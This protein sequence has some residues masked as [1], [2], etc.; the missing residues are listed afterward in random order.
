MA[1]LVLLK[2]TEPNSRNVS[3]ESLGKVI[4][5]KSQSSLLLSVLDISKLNCILPTAFKK[6]RNVCLRWPEKSDVK[7]DN[8]KQERLNWQIICIENY[9]SYA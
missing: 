1:A 6:Q 3:W 8:L 2:S 7:K 5:Q 9:S 4:K